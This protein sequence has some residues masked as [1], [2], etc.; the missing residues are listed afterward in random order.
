M[1]AS[2]V[3]NGEFIRRRYNGKDHWGSREGS[4]ADQVGSWMGGRIQGA[5]LEDT[6][7]SPC[8][9]GTHSSRMVGSSRQ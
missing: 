7:T 5:E 8:K 6:A 4:R 9:F 2:D 1:S 3:F